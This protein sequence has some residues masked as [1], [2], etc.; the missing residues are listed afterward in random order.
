MKKMTTLWLALLTATAGLCLLFY[1]CKKHGETTTSLPTEPADVIAK[2]KASIAA[3]ISK[4]GIP[5]TVPVN[6][7]LVSQW[8]DSSGHTFTQAQLEQLVAKSHGG[9]FVDAITSACDYSNVPTV[10]LLSYTIANDCINGYKVSWTFQVSSNNNIVSANGTTTS[11]GYLRVYSGTSPT[12]LLYS[13][14]VTP[15]TVADMGADP[16]NSGYELFNVSFTS[17]YV[18]NS[19]PYITPTGSSNV[20]LGGFFVTNCSDLEPITAGIQA[21]SATNFTYPSGQPCTRID[22]IWINSGTGLT[23]TVFGEDPTGKCTGTGYVF[24]SWQEVQCSEDGGTTWSTTYLS[25]NITGCPFA[26]F[27]GKQY[28]DPFGIAYLVYD[29]THLSAGAHTILFRSRDV[30]Y[31]SAGSTSCSGTIVQYPLPPAWGACTGTWS[32]SYSYGVTR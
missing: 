29:Y 6:E 9:H 17:G 7:K 25:Y 13:A 28:V 18:S 3:Q 14:N 8:A 15:A 26:N 2:T 32:S 16:S 19:D 1:A 12:T 30:Y 11:K 4:N 5:I 24:P 22:P 10:T 23:L 21:Y 27:I 31:T 20:K